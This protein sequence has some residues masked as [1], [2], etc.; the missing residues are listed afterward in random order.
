MTLATSF[1]LHVTLVCIHND[2]Q[3]EYFSVN[4]WPDMNNQQYVKIKCVYTSKLFIDFSGWLITLV[5][6]FSDEK[7][8]ASVFQLFKL[9]KSDVIP[10][11]GNK[12]TFI[13]F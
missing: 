3:V 12:I 7:W 5:E 8:W 9:L 4:S 1:I 13:T 6:Y 2:S 11:E 10:L